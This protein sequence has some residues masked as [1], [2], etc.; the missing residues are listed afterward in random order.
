[1]AIIPKTRKCDGIPIFYID[2]RDQKKRRVREKAGTTRSQ[3][4]NLLTQRLGQV[5]DGTYVNPKDVDRDAGPTFTEFA[6]RFMKDYGNLR[7]SNYYEEQVKVLKRHFGERRLRDITRADLDLFTAARSRTAGPSTVRK[8]LTI[9]GTM[10]KLAV[11][12]DVLQ[13]SPAVDLNK[14]SEPHHKTRYLSREEWDRLHDAAPP[15]LRPIITMAVV[16]G[17]RLKEVVGLQWE[18]VDSVAGVV[19]IS[20]DNKTGRPRGIPI[21]DTV[22][23]V[24]AERDKVRDLR[25]GKR[26][27]RFVF[28]DTAGEARTS[29]RAR[30]TICKA[31]IS[32][33]KVAGLAGVSFHTLRHTAGSWAAQAGATEIEIAKLLGHAT[34]ATTRR[35]THLKPDHLRGTVRALD[36]MMRGVDTQVDTS[37]ISEAVN[38]KAG[39]VNSL[40]R[41]S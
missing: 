16:T 32:A 6:E 13:A 38:E 40:Q 12:W 1:M 41:V 24:L 34:T 10:F 29:T 26:L 20:E 18:D 4:K 3:A 22:R 17:M 25:T 7:R 14:P 19:H 2:F 39:S 5:R 36:A 37:Q 27:S 28:T 23:E 21:G 11:R 31:T 30:D 15:W 8:N 35:Y 9:L 33:A